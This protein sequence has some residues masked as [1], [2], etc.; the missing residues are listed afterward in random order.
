MESRLLSSIPFFLTATHKSDMASISQRSGRKEVR[1]VW[2]SMV[3]VVG[4]PP[5][6]TIVLE[7]NYG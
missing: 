2:W 1:G 3:N 6:P 5:Q 4:L 7:N